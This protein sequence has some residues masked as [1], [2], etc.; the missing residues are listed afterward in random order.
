MGSC[1]IVEADKKNY[2][3]L[4]ILCQLHV[5]CLQRLENRSDKNQ[6]Q[7]HPHTQSSFGA[8]GEL[9]RSLEHF[10]YFHEAEFSH[11]E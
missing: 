6:F 3:I 4:D 2:G 7:E 5:P 11:S 1:R 9:S 10:H 8:L